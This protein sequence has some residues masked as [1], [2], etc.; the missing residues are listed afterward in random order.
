MCKSIITFKKFLKLF[1]EFMF[2]NILISFAFIFTGYSS[3]S[4]KSFFLNTIV[5]F[6]DVSN[7][8]VGC[9]LL[10]FLF[11]PFLNILLTNLSEKQHM[12]LV[13]LCLFV[14]SFFGTLPYFSINMNYISWFI[15]LYLI[16]SYIRLYP[17][18]IF[19][20]TMLWGDYHFYLLLCLY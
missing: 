20:K 19:Q 11:I 12:I 9:Y 18:A 4:L 13:F 8:F 10:F 15:V 2:Y 6:R 14:Y 3:F 7:N 17:R 5:P 16:S 1:F